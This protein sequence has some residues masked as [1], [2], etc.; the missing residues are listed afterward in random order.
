MEAPF[1][2]NFCEVSQNFRVSCCLEFSKS[3]QN[4]LIFATIMQFPK[5]PSVFDKSNLCFNEEV[6]VDEKVSHCLNTCCCHCCN[7]L[8]PLKSFFLPNST[9]RRVQMICFLP[10]FLVVNLL[11][12][13][14]LLTGQLINTAREGAKQFVRLPHLA[15]RDD[16]DCFVYCIHECLSCWQKSTS[17]ANRTASFSISLCLVHYS[18][19]LDSIDVSCFKIYC[20]ISVLGKVNKRPL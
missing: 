14:H 1:T 4:W 17:L 10:G 7:L 13:V 19:E 12:G 5:K 16:W 15:W 18:T 20:H 11:A 6:P 9:L 8:E 2:R 3:C